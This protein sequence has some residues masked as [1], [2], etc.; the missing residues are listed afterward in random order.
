VVAVA[1]YSIET[2]RLLLL[3]ACDRFPDGVCNE[4]G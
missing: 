4:Y 1:A 2:P 3:S